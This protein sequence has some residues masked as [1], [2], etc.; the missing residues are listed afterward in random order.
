MKNLLMRVI[1]L[2]RIKGTKGV[3]ALRIADTTDS[4]SSKAFSGGK[5]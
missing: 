3:Y 5:S 4:I 1:H 2:T